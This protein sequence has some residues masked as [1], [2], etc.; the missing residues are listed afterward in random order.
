MEQNNFDLLLILKA[1]VENDQ[2]IIETKTVSEEISKFSEMTEQEFQTIFL[3]I[4]K[5]IF[6]RYKEKKEKTKD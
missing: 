4:S 2:L 3:N 5:N 1:N 6:K